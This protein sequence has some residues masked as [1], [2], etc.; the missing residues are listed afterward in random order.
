MP[1]PDTPHAVAG[2]TA[3]AV[4]YIKESYIAMLKTNLT[5]RNPLQFF[6]GQSEDILAPGQFGGV[7]ARAGVGKTALMVQIALNSML[8]ERNVLHI[9]LNQPVNKASL[10]YRDI[11]GHLAAGHPAPQTDQLWESLLPHRFIMTFRAESFSV[12]RLEERLTDLIEQKIFIPRMLIVDGLSFDESIRDMLSE[13]KKLARLHGLYTWFSI[14]THRH[15]DPGPGGVPKQLADV[16]DLFAVAIQLTPVGE[17]IHVRP[18][19]GVSLPPEHARLIL[20]PTTMLLKDTA[21]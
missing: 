11:F 1:F 7:L 6:G 8:N 16:D 17:E 2:Q 4:I 3:T 10:W 20:D 14:R 19:K 21:A 12:P 18:L 9:S 15:Q 5:L 13:L